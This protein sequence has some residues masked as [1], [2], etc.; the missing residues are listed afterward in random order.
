MVKPA[1]RLAKQAKL[2]VSEVE[3]TD[4]LRS[5]TVSL[6]RPTMEDGDTE[7]GDLIPD[8]SAAD[9]TETV[10]DTMRSE[11]L[12]E[13]LQRLSPRT[14]RILELR[15]GLAGGE[16]MMLDAVGREVGL[17]RERV[18]QIEVE[19]LGQLAK[20]PELAGIADAA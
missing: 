15:F 3:D 10:A 2:K 16:P 1:A 20:M 7:L 4:K 11:T 14:R 18:R 19:A 12:G 8:E 6:Q 5:Q 9:V 17:T 13:A